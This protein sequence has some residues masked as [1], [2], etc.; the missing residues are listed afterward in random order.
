MVHARRIRGA[1]CLLI[2]SVLILSVP[3]T[4]QARPKKI[5]GYYYGKSSSTGYRFDKIPVELLTHLIY[6]Q[7]RPTSKG[8]CALGHPDV[9]LS[10]LAWLSALKGRNPH[11][12]ILLSVGGWSGSAYFS[13]LAA[14]AEAR[15]KFSAS[16][17][18]LVKKYGFDGLDIDWEYPVTGGKPTDHKRMSDKENF[19][20]LLEQL[21]SDLDALE[22]GRHPLLTIASTCY[23]AHLGDL[24]T[25][26]L[27]RVL[28]WF[29]IMCYD[30]N[31]MEPKL[32]FHHSGLFASETSRK[33]VGDAKYANCDAAVQWYL[34]QGVPAAK[35]VLGVPFYGQIWSDVSDVN[36]GL[37][38][39]FGGR[40]VE[41][42]VLS[43]RE[44]DESYLAIYSRQWDDEAKVPWLYSR[45]TK[46]MI[47]YEDAESL[48]AKADYV[49]KKDLAGIMFWDIA[50]D[51]SR[52]TLL[53][54]IY[55]RLVVRGPTESHPK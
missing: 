10:N 34:D 28:D 29:N 43:F 24:A 49:L 3:S 18:E 35:I 41:D 36:H 44:I 40:P 47:S 42:G 17:M 51:D 30:M 14:T 11:L 15:R 52:F 38:Q 50:Q 8:V 7:A 32:T 19:V 27:A 13:D 46:A 6:S 12:L 45:K 4:A 2:C 16:C 21:R 26:G 20:L 39:R 37:Y 54:T 31:E 22:K 1:G 25:G 55:N 23:H 5:V 33:A 53:N 9:D 48:T